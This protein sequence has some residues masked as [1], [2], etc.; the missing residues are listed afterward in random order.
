[1][2]PR[3][4]ET[5]VQQL[6]QSTAAEAACD[7][8][9]VR[10]FIRSR[11][12]GE[13][14]F[15]ALVKRHGPLVLES[16]TVSWGTPT[17]PKTCSR[18]RS[19]FSRGGRLDSAARHVG[20]WL[21]G[22]A[23]RTALDARRAIHRR[24][25]K[26]NAAMHRAEPRPPDSTD[27]AAV[28]DQELAGLPESCGPRSSCARFMDGPAGRSHANSASPRGPSRA[29]SHAAARSWQCAGTPRPTRVAVALL[30]MFASAAVSASLV[31]TTVKTALGTATTGAVPML[32][33]GVM[34]AM[35]FNRLKNA[36]V[37][38]LIACFA[39]LG[40]GMFAGSPNAS[41]Q[42]QPARRTP[43]QPR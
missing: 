9:L 37:V 38:V 14:A 2:P 18:P 32:A 19:W 29:G 41:G 34:K 40:L 4:L 12:E 26:E 30:A 3:A 28:L 11:A 6:R 25:E 17:M 22:V 10:T 1:M 15:A 35:L 16:P 27:L 21:Y 43:L 7:A 24:R 13:M 23:R 39:C 31:A 20:N 8:D 42:P 5:I 33:Q 36:A